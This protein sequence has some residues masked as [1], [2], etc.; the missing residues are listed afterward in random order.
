MCGGDGLGCGCGVGNLG[1]VLGG[2]W[3]VCFVV[4]GGW[5]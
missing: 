5:C 3:L 4:V 1:V 2:G